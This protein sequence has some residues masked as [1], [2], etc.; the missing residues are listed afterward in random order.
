MSIKKSFLPVYEIMVANP[1]MTVS[2]LLPVVEPLMVTRK[3]AGR[4][5][6]MSY[7][8]ETG[9][10]V[11]I[12]CYYYKKWLPTSCVE[13]GV[14]NNSATGLNTMCKFGV[15]LWTQQQRAYRKGKEALLDALASSEVSPSDIDAKLAEL[16]KARVHIEEFPYP[17]WS[18]ETLEELLASEYAKRD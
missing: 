2:E 1:R 10:V 17:E 6:T 5:T 11:A 7:R 3:G 12:R 9:K 18:F 15:Q 16:E 8:D 13:F 4:S 14:K